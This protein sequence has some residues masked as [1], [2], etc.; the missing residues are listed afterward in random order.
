[1]LKCLPLRDMTGIFTIAVYSLFALFIC[2]LKITLGLIASVNPRQLMA[3]AK[4]LG[5]WSTSVQ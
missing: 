5:D 2:Y 1:M 4:S 3:A